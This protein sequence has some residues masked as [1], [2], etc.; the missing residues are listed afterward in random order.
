MRRFTALC[1]DNKTNYE[2]LASECSFNMACNFLTQNGFIDPDTM[3]EINGMTYMEFWTPK[4]TRTF[5][6]DEAR[7][8]L[9][10]VPD[11]MI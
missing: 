9:M 1:I 10:E 4:G 11:G 8:Y 6:Y 5:C 3:I 7:G 2:M